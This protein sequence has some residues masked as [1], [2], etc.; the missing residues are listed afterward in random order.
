VFPEVVRVASTPGGPQRVTVKLQPEALGEVRVVLTTHRGELRV[1][2]GAEGHAHHALLEGAPELRRQ[3]E[4]VGVADA[5]I[6]VRDLPGGTGGT[7]SSAQT[8]TQ[9]DPQTSP[10]GRQD[11]DRQG[12]AAGD[13]GGSG[14]SGTGRGDHTTTHGRSTAT[15]GTPGATTTSRR[16]E[17]VTR[18]RAAGLDVTM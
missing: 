10:D 7:G 11:A 1:S 4:A 3:L 17:T 6:V 16:T 9:P 8:G 14:G 15:D 18:T 5:R 13:P 2:L 12:A